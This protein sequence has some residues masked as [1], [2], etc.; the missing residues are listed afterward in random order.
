LTDKLIE[1]FEGNP[2]LF[3]GLIN[4]QRWDWSKKFSVIRLS[5]GHPIGKP[6]QRW[7][8]RR[9]CAFGWPVGCEA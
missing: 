8:H 3:T 1:V 4:W 7:P 5:V 6:L 9:R 2:A